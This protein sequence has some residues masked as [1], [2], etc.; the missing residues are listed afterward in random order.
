MARMWSAMSVDRT[1]EST[2]AAIC[3]LDP[4]EFMLEDPAGQ[5]LLHNP[6]Y[7]QAPVPIGRSEPFVID[8]REAVEV[9]HQQEEWGGL[10]AAGP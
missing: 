6:A 9:V 4:G 1:S 2:W 5:E 3:L 10:R 8:R 7:H